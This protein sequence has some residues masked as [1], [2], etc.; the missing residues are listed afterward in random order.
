MVGEEL[1]LQTGTDARLGIEGRMTIVHFRAGKNV[2]NANA[3]IPL[4]QIGRLTVIPDV[5]D[6]LMIRGMQSNIGLG[7]AGKFGDI[8]QLFLYH[9]IDIQFLFFAQSPFGKLFC[10]QRYGDRSGSLDPVYQHFD[11][12][13]QCQIAS[14]DRYHFSKAYYFSGGPYQLRQAAE[15]TGHFVLKEQMVV[16]DEMLPDM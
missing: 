4:R 12:R 6:D 7:G 1:D 14:A 11:I 15:V 16:F 3:I 2:G 9:P 8:A 5:E 10:I 13:D